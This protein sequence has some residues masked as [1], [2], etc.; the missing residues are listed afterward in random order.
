MARSIVDVL[1]TPEQRYVTFE[2]T[3]SSNLGANC[4]KNIS[5]RRR[6]LSVI[7]AHCGPT[8]MD[9]RRYLGRTVC[10]QCIMNDK[11]KTPQ[12]EGLK[13][14]L[15]VQLL[16]AIL[17]VNG[18]TYN[19]CEKCLCESW[20]LTTDETERTTSLKPAQQQRPQTV[21]LGEMHRAQTVNATAIGTADW[22][23]C[24]PPLQL[25]AQYCKQNVGPT[26]T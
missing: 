8:L 1:E 16:H 19:F 9:I 2:V 22:G 24:C 11:K 13:L 18:S 15:H 6:F 3:S 23:L 20:T 17:L 12:S 26:L 14:W 4:S 10:P 21:E 25:W 5:W 7:R